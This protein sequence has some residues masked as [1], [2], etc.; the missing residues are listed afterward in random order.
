MASSP[1]PRIRLLALDLDGT[2]VS[3]EAEISPRT[4]EA[5]H[6]AHASGVCVAIATG[7]RYRRTQIVV[8]ALGMRAPV[9]CLGGALVKGEDGT[10]LRADRFAPDELRQLASLLRELGHAAVAQLEGEEGR[11]DFVIDGALPWNG[12]TRRYWERYQ[13]QAQWSRSLADEQRGDALVLGAFAERSPLR[14]LVKQIEQRFPGRFA[15]VVTP[16]PRDE[17]GCYLEIV[18]HHVSKWAGVRELATHVGVPEDAICAVGDERNDLSM[19]R[20]AALGIAMG[21]AHP[22]VRAVADWVTGRH[23]EDGL[24]A[25]VDRILS[26]RMS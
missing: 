1:S 6:R 9:V 21:N 25:V 19:I 2:L 22:E 7:R 5:L 13:D 3:G 4:R 26:D 15:V 16:L 23:D 17:R 10:T 14:A 11:P 24:V 20:S 8:E 18:P 12:W